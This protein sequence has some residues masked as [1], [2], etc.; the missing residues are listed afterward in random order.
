MQ[1]GCPLFRLAEVLSVIGTQGQGVREQAFLFVAVFDYEGSGPEWCISSML[2]SQDTPFGSGT[3][4][5]M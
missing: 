3:L 4:D 5:F 1:G 2:C